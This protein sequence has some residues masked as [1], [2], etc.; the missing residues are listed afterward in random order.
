MTGC[1]PHGRGCGADTA[2]AALVN[3]LICCWPLNIPLRSEQARQPA[4]GRRRKAKEGEGRKRD[5]VSAWH[6]PAAPRPG[7]SAPRCPPGAPSAPTIRSVRSAPATLPTGNVQQ[8]R[9]IGSF[10]CLRVPKDSHLIDHV[11]LLLEKP[12]V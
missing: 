11:F 2:R 10:L 1:A 4:Q 8:P 7:P 9:M 12:R 6:M 5:G 3:M